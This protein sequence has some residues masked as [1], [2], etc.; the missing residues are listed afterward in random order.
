MK[1]TSWWHKICI[2]YFM[3]SQSAW[4]SEVHVHQQFQLIST[5]LSIV[6]DSCKLSYRFCWSSTLSTPSY[7]D[8]RTSY[9]LQNCQWYRYGGWFFKYFTN[10]VKY[11]RISVSSST[12]FRIHFHLLFVWVP[13]K[14]FETQAYSWTIYKY[15]IL[16]RMCV[17]TTYSL[18]LS[19][20][21]TQMYKCD[22]H[23]NIS[24]QP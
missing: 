10:I 12:Y 2:A 9:S 19:D 13:H 8:I 15:T 23:I 1:S 7:N 6:T 22:L 5:V 21:R 20:S 4:Y 11:M 24:P 16:I 17:N 14:S 3:T 18:K